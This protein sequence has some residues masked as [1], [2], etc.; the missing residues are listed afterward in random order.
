MDSMIG[1]I[2]W[3]KNGTIYCHDAS[4]ALG[5]LFTQV[6]TYNENVEMEKQD[7]TLSTYT[8]NVEGFKF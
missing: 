6:A 8:Q 1:T 2:L 4:D 7:L 3:F 5:S